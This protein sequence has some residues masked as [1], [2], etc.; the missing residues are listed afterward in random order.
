MYTA[1]FGG[2]LLHFELHFSFLFFFLFFFFSFL[3]IFGIGLP[4]YL[5]YWVCIRR[6]SLSACVEVICCIVSGF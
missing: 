1:S 6:I 4:P 5:E 2:L 3:Q